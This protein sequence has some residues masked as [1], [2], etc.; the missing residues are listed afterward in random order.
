LIDSFQGQ[1]RFLSN[2][3]PSPLLYMGVIWP[4]VEHLFQAMKLGNQPDER[5]A[6]C[7]TP[8]LAKKMGRTIPLRADWQVVKTKVMLYCL[9][10]KFAQPGFREQL[11]STLPHELVEGNQW[12]DNYWGKCFCGSCANKIHNDVLGRLLIQV[13]K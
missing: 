13:R 3:F 8:A 5:V 12:H 11:L 9:R 1:Y 6:G 7:A 10:L 4:T 2:F